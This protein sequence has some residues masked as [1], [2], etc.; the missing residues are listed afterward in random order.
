MAN[1]E[2]SDGPLTLTEPQQQMFDQLEKRLGEIMLK[3]HSMSDVEPDD[4]KAIY[5]VAAQLHKSLN[6]SGIEVR[7]QWQILNRRREF[8][9]R[10]RN[11]VRWHRVNQRRCGIQCG[12]LQRWRQE[13]KKD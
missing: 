5:Q 3:F 9:F 2:K 4:L 11:R 10:G 12:G 13:G 7:H 1:V 8:G 6:E